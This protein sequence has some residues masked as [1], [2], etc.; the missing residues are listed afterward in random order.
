MKEFLDSVLQK[1]K[2]NVQVSLDPVTVGL[3]AI[4]LFLA[5]FMGL[6]LYSIEP[7]CPPVDGEREGDDGKA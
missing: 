5:I 4:G 6:F 7:G 1:G 3:V 2:I